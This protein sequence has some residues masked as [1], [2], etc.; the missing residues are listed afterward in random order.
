MA[1]ESR[2]RDRLPVL[3]TESEQ[4]EATLPHRPGDPSPHRPAS[5]GGGSLQP[6][7]WINDNLQLIRLLG[8]GGMGSVWVAHH[9]TLDTEVAVKFVSA[10]LEQKEELLSRFKREARIAAKI[11]SPHVVEV[12]DLGRTDDDLPYIAMELLVGESL[13]DRLAREPQLSP[14]EAVALVE[15]VAEALT[16]AHALDVIHRDI[17]PHNIFL[18]KSKTKFLWAKVLDFGIAKSQVESIDTTTV[19]TAVG[20]VVGTPLYMCPDQLLECKPASPQSDLWSL[21]VVLYQALTGKLPF[22]GTTTAALGAALSKRACV[23]PSVLRPELGDDVDAWFAKA[24]EPDAADRFQTA[25]EMAESFRDAIEASPTIV[26]RSARDL[27]M[28][29]EYGAATPPGSVKSARTL[30]GAASTLGGTQSRLG[31]RVG[32]LA[33]VFFVGAGVVFAGA[34]GLGAWGESEPAVGEQS[35]IPAADPEPPETAEPTS[36]STPEVAAAP[37]ASAAT[38]SAA[39][40]VSATAVPA[41]V[42]P[43][44]IPSKPTATAESSASPSEPPKPSGPPAYCADP[45]KAFVVDDKGIHR[46]K[47]ECR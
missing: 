10:G 45:D 21:A 32:L 29:E 5:D 46:L 14:E 25:L 40:A 33:L 16:E 11:K 17:K 20:A 2:E 27:P 7:R 19:E 42:S 41:R 35:A 26:L 37:A 22:E 8:Q 39:P 28:S 43:A 4:D 13:A 18:A 36:T 6:G 24:F 23:A 31:N 1:G 34:I 30:D 12:L 9:D 3:H 38:S 47:P 44:K 15:Q